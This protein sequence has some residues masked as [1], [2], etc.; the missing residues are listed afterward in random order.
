MEKQ[1]G[2]SETQPE[3]QLSDQGAPGGLGTALPAGHLGSWA[4]LGGDGP[5][6]VL[7]AAPG[8]LQWLLLSLLAQGGRDALFLGEHAGILSC[9]GHLV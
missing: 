9:R 5:C 3:L 7:W 1:R 4:S 6:G 8:L 2:H